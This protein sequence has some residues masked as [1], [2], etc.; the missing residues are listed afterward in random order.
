MNWSL[1]MSD[2][3]PT[4]EQLWTRLS[5]WGTADW[6]RLM[7]RADLIRISE[8]CIRALDKIQEQVTEIARL[9][10][11]IE[12]TMR[13]LTEQKQA[14]E[15]LERQ[16]AQSCHDARSD[17]EFGGCPV[18]RIAVLQ[19]QHERDCAV[20]DAKRLLEKLE[21]IRIRTLNLA[22]WIDKGCD[23]R[24]GAIEASFIALMAK[25][26]AADVGD[27]PSTGEKNV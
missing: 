25:E 18:G 27:E 15:R 19:A 17:A 14:N 1:K 8:D 10:A 22:Q 12:T 6:T 13:C 7:D 3:K 5:N 24:Y 16:I 26:P 4:D 21:S 2:A 9:N 20:E 23:P 11:M